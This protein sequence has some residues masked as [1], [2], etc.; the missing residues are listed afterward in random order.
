MIASLFRKSTPFNYTVLIVI[1][2]VFYLLFQFSG[3]AKG[4]DAIGI[5]EKVFL[6]SLVFSSLFILNFIV[7]KNGMSRDNSYA[8]LFYFLFVL[9]FPYAFDNFNLMVSN[10][11]VLLALRRLIS[12]QS[13]KAPKEK[14]FDASLWIFLAAIFHFWSI[15]FIALVFISILFHVSRDFR[16]WILPFIAFIAAIVLFFL[17]AFIFDETRIAFVMSNIPIDVSIDY[18]TDTKQN[19]ALSIFAPVV[20]YYLVVTLMTLSSRPLILQSSYKKVISAFFI[21]L[22]VFIISPHKSNEV[23]MYTFAPLAIMAS[24]IVETTS[25]ELK[26]ELMV[27]LTAVLAIV[28]F[29]MQL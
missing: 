14:I 17:F 16:N 2:A 18:F 26:R 15:L 3:S 24:T 12:L 5:V 8:I 20:V 4:N 27:G 28:S 19:L 10:F 9:F 11:L 7:K 29:F 23:L 6:F 21:G 13:L 25:S 22:A 1:V